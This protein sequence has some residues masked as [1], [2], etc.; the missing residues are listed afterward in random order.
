MAACRIMI[1]A[2]RSKTDKE[3][4]Q[5]LRTALDMATLAVSLN[6]SEVRKP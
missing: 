3:R 2:M 1:L 6:E 5:G 4:A